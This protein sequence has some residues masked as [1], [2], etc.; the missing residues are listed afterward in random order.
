M[1]SFLV[2]LT[3]GLRIAANAATQLYTFLQNRALFLNGTV[4]ENNK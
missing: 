1:Q 3:T 2:E 4:N